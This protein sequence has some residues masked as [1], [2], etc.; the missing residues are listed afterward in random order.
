MSEIKRLMASGIM[1]A[2]VRVEETR[3]H[4]REGHKRTGTWLAGLTGESVGQAA[5]MLEAA[6]SIEP[7][8]RSQKPSGRD[9]FQRR[10]R[11]R[12]RLRQTPVPTRRRTSS[13]RRQRWSSEP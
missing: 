7:I 1:R 10:R 3:L 6:R 8:P 4:E 5:S 2:A 11:R 9:H 12:S 13:K